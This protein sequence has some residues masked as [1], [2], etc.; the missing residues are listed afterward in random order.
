MTEL[1]PPSTMS[2]SDTDESTIMLSANSSTA[3]DISCAKDTAFQFQS[4]SSNEVEAISQAE[5]STSDIDNMVITRLDSSSSIR[6]RAI[7][8]EN[9]PLT[10]KT[11]CVVEES[12]TTSSLQHVIT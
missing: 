4:A 9:V 12:T 6:P 3:T 5:P 8:P 11:S 2:R 1:S 7:T 10:S